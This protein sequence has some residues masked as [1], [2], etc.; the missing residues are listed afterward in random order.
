MHAREIAGSYT[1]YSIGIICSAPP[2]D[3]AQV[4]RGHLQLFESRKG[5][6]RNL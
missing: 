2:E 1:V 5:P 6:D 3:R 4:P